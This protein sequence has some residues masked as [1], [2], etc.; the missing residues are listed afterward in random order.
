MRRDDSLNDQ[1]GRSGLSRRMVFTSGIAAAFGSAIASCTKPRPPSEPPPTLDATSGQIS[2]GGQPVAGFAVVTDRQFEGGADPQAKRDSGPAIRAA[3]ATGK[4][5]YLPP[6]AYLYS[7][8]G[9]DHHSPVIVGAGQGSTTVTLSPDTHFIDSNQRWL[10][11]NLTGIRFNGG[12]GHVRNRYRDSNV[13]DFHVVSDCA[14]IG[15]S[16]CSIST[17]SVDNP[18]W[19]INRNIFRAA[20]FGTSMGI[21]LSGL[22][23]G[24]SIADNS[25]LSNRVHIK[26]CEGG[27][28]TYITN[29]DFLRF[30]PPEGFPRTDVWFVPAQ[31][32]V[33]AGGGMVLSR[34]KFGN[35]NLDSHDHHIVY[36]DESSGDWN[37]GRW[38]LLEQA[39]ARW[40]TG[41]TITDVYSNGIGDNARIPLIRSTTSNIVGGSYGPITQGGNSGASILS[42]IEPLR[43]NGISNR[44]GPLLRANSILGPLPEL[45]V[46]DHN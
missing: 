4:P 24:T 10:R 11:L 30:G 7:G 6:G 35:E 25:F 38:P 22:T 20:N 44:F 32:D 9:I 39:S 18:Y 13:N 8:P 45:V 36:A 29:N 2:I 37:G 15:Y 17:N 27:N 28:N 43:D 23:D 40:I 3:V 31:T 19:K 33:N 21:A 46:S 34:C 5:V 42:T 16:G 12:I 41:H 1:P 14:F 26:L